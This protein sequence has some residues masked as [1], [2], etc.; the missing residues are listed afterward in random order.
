MNMDVSM[1]LLLEV[2]QLG[3]STSSS[4]EHPRTA[5]LPIGSNKVSLRYCRILENRNS[6]Y[7]PSA[8]QKGVSSP[9]HI[10]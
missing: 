2:L 10:V 9:L 7:R 4:V 1:S 5:T 6:Y 8:L 3:R